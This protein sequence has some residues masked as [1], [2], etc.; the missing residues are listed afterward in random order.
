[1]ETDVKVLKR[2]VASMAAKLA[3]EEAETT[4]AK[5]EECIGPAIDMACKNLG[6]TSNVFIK[7]YL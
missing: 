5:Y 7:M 1:M 2:K 3:Q 4:G 6:I